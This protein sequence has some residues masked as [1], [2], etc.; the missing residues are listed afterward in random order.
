MK[1]GKID[2]LEWRQI[3]GF[4]YL[5]ENNDSNGIIISLITN[6]FDHFHIFEFDGFNGESWSNSGD[7]IFNNLIFNVQFFPCK[8]S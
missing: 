2:Q 6:Y 7:K 1:T 4:N 3:K 5:Y 8:V